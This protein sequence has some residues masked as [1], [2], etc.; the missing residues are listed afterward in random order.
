MLFA[1]GHRVLHAVSGLF[2]ASVAVIPAYA[3]GPPQQPT[4][5]QINAIRARYVR[6]GPVLVPDGGSASVASYS[7]LREG[8][9]EAGVPGLAKVPYLS[10]GFGN[11][12]AGRSASRV[13]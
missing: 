3:G 6:V 7:T 4:P 10:R 12:A 5:E 8:R 1:A 9:I 13:G 11:L 2:L